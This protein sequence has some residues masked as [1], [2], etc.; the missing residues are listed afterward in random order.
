MK[1]QTLWAQGHPGTRRKASRFGSRRAVLTA[2]LPLVLAGCTA[3]GE[4]QDQLTAALTEDPPP[5][6]Q[7]SPPAPDEELASN[8]PTP[9]PKPPIPERFASLPP[10]TAQGAPAEPGETVV[11]DAAASD[12]AVLEASPDTATDAVQ[13]AYANTNPD[14]LIGAVPGEIITVLGE[15]T[16]R[17]Q[18]PPAEIW[19]YDSRSCTLRLTLL[20]DVVTEEHRSVFYEVKSANPEVRNGDRNCVAELLANQRARS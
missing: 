3:I 14:R 11:A 19:Q 16:Q 2:V 1:A 18:E 7:Q 4:F 15:P 8:V 10:E 13:L 9:R 12:A 5:D 17:L 6:V 20:L